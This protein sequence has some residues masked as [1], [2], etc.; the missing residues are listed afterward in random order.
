IDRYQN[1][2]GRVPRVEDTRLILITDLGFIVKQAK[3]GTR[4]VF[5]Q[6]IRSGEPVDGARI[7]VIGQNGQPA[8]A[9]TTD[10]GGRA[11]LP[12][13]SDFKRE[14]APLLILAQKGDD[15]SF[16]P[17]RTSGRTLDLSRFDTGGV[18]NAESS[19]Q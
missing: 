16:M 1:G 10:R 2:F 3:D 13:T 4:D 11:Q 9:A 15:F 7:E 18:E 19:Q 17:L 6:S 12:K 5:V 14:K 8:L